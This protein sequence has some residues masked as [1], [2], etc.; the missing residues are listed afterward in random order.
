MERKILNTYK[1]EFF[2]QES[3]PSWAMGFREKMH[4]RFIHFI[5]IL[6]DHYSGIGFHDQSIRVY[7]NGLEIDPYEELFYQ[8]LMLLHISQGRSAEAAVL[9]KRCESLLLQAMNREPSEKTRSIYHSITKTSRQ[10]Y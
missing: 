9:Y 1:G 3:V 6:A 7:K 8:N 4:T 2:T 5:Q 10:V